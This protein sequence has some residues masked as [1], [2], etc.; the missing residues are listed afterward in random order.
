MPLPIPPSAPVSLPLIS[1]RR[2]GV[3]GDSR[4]NNIGGYFSLLPT[5]GTNGSGL[6]YTAIATG[7]TVT[8]STG[9]LS[10]PVIANQ[11]VDIHFWDVSTLYKGTGLSGP[12]PSLNGDTVG[13]ADAQNGTTITVATNSVA[14][15]GSSQTLVTNQQNGK[16]SVLSDNSNGGYALSTP[17]TVSPSQDFTAVW[18]GKA[19]GDL[20]AVFGNTSANIQFAVTPGGSNVLSYYDGTG[21]GV[22]SATISPNLRSGYHIIMFRR[23][24]SGNVTFRVDGVNYTGGNAGTPT[25]FTINALDD[26][27]DDSNKLG[28]KLYAS[29][30]QRRITDNECGQIEVYLNSVLLSLTT[31]ASF[32]TSLVPSTATADWLPTATTWT[33]LGYVFTGATSQNFYNRATAAFQAAGVDTVLLG[34]GVNDAITG[35]STGTVQTNMGTIIDQLVA[36]G[37]RVLVDIP[38]RTTSI[39]TGTMDGYKTAIQTAS[40]ARS[41]VRVLVGTTGNYD[42]WA[43]NITNVTLCADGVHPTAAGQVF[44]ESYLGSNLSRGLRALNTIPSAYSYFSRKTVADAN[45]TILNANRL[46]AYTTLT[47]G[48][49]I[50]LPTAVGIAGQQFVIKDESGSANSFNITV[51]TTS[52]QTID[53][54][55]TKVISTSYGV[56]RLYSNGTNWLTF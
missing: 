53:G 27:S 22:T 42:F 39:S 5:N 41:A 33:T 15:N 9:L 21:G 25:S 26:H 43:T 17:I 12:R 52:A 1:S 11:T 20:R 54:A 4:Y 3:I 40:N 46:I 30:F 28:N 24:D 10:E 56:L 38:F 2:L 48:R 50:T 13:S 18:F 32:N 47:A 6:N 35:V 23:D 14:G 19:N 29:W 51:A 34:I 55:A 36:D 8:F 44:Q 7:S 16:P 31:D 37:Y 49:T 45:Y